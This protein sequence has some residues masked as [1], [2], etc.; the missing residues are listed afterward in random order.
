M[1]LERRLIRPAEQ[2]TALIYG[3]PLLCLA[4]GFGAAL[5]SGHVPGPVRFAAAPAAA[6]LA[7]VL[8]LG[9][10]LWQWHTEWRTGFYTT[11]QALAPTKIWHQLVV[12]PVFGTLITFSCL[13][14]LAAPPGGHPAI[15]L[16][17]KLLIT[18]CGLAWTVMNIYDR[19]HPR[20]GHPPFD[21]RHLRPAR[22]QE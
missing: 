4:C 11:A 18:A 15:R 21:W 12:Y 9:F 8:W 19:R 2:F 13:A 20:Y 17:M 5:A 3:D 1:T 14:A 16:I 7:A 6:G 10:G 22:D